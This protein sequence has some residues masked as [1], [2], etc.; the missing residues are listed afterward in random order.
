MH[1]T[2]AEKNFP[3]CFC[4]VLQYSPC[5]LWLALSRYPIL[6]TKI[7]VRRFQFR[8]TQATP[9]GFQ[10]GVDRGA[11]TTILIFFCDIFF[12]FKKYWILFQFFS[13]WLRLL[14]KVTKV[15]TEHQKCPKIG[16]NRIISSFFCPKDK[17]NLG[18]RPKPSAEVKN[19][20]P[21][22]D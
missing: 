6:N 4:I 15:I 1:D 18:Q 3:S 20:R 21:Q 12:I 13:N 2:T 16:Q 7:S 22:E 17:K 9:P 5:P 10:N 14:I 11:L 8:N 19:T